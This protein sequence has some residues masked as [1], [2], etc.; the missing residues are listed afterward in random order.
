MPDTIQQAFFKCRR[1]I[2]DC[3]FSHLN[4]MQRKA[5]FHT[6]GPL[7]ILAGA[8]S[9]KTTVLVN[10]IACI[11][12]YGQAYDSD[13]APR[14]LAGEDLDYL[15]EC[16]AARR[17]ND[18]RLR[19]LL[20]VS[21][22][23]PWSV[24]AITFTN[25]AA[26][27][28]KDRL[29]S[30]LGPQAA[31]VWACTFHSAC[32]R[33]LRRNI[34][35]L[36]M[37]YT[38]SFTIYDTDD[39]VRVLRDVCREIDDERSFANKVALPGISRAKELYLDPDGYERAAGGDFR[40]K[41][42][43]RAY[44]GYQ[45]ALRRANA[46]DFDD[47][48]VL[49]VRLLQACPDVLEYYQ[50][51]F[52]HI[53][54][55]EYQDTNHVQYMLVSL[56]ASGSRNICVVGDDD[57]SIYG[58]R[59]ATIE[60]ILSFEK[61][62]KD[63]CV[64]KLEQNY[65]STST[66]LDAANAVI[67]NNIGRKG[68][69]LWTDKGQGEKISVCRFEDEA[70]ESQYFANVI[71]DDVQRG[72][73]FS[74][75]AVLYRM[76]AQSASIEKAFV[77]NG[78]P[79][80]I[81]G[82]FRFYERLEVKDIVSYLVVLNN[83]EDNL[84]F[85]RIVNAPK[86]SIGTATLNAA[87]EIMEREGVSLYEVFLHCREYPYFSKKV[88]RI[89]GF[90]QF[91]EEMR[92]LIDRIPLGD[93]TRQVIEKSGYLDELRA[94]QSR[95]SADRIENLKTLVSNA[96]LYEKESP[97]PSLAGFLEESALMADIDNYDSTA[98]TVVMMT[99]H[100]AKGLEFPVVFLAGME[101]GVFPSQNSAIEPQEL[102]EER[103]LAYVGITRAREKLYM[104]YANIRM[105]FGSTVYNRPSRF[106]EEVP[107]ELKEVLS[108]RQTPAGRHRAP[109]RHAAPDGDRVSVSVQSRAQAVFTPGDIVRHNTFGKGMVL[110]AKP[111]G[112]DVLLE[113]AFD[114]YGTKKLMANFARLSKA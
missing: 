103:R 106:I 7:L 98:D 113:I 20:A 51:R 18:D 14:S 3:E 104:T 114:T 100:S 57:Q 73:K 63:A 46:L 39:S 6:E 45:E 44:H 88:G 33:I 9:G 11:L 56:L 40:L 37:G 55:D 69:E 16:L 30:M 42:I 96:A 1:Q 110:S 71:L 28:L 83:P 82:G 95:E 81:I 36:D 58:F 74:E 79:Y 105:L 67:A 91:L 4:D 17:F 80:R 23:P 12:K 78:I 47:I 24:L 35:R 111:M 97:E 50:R 99:L 25:K 19:S 76:N 15:K 64:I 21:S 43:A 32:V 10:R 68:K 49:T 77:R 62:F 61:Q 38:R 8:G 31:E 54:V 107:E 5:V 65:R 26:N 84:H 92:G 101:E 34:D 66:I 22:A 48:L 90:M 41:K 70:G 86:R 75:H 102:E 112:G 87:T 13:A 85:R 93:L 60:N 53:L 108:R 29:S 94:D 89:E 109:A 72:R 2:M 52:R 59:G 27:E